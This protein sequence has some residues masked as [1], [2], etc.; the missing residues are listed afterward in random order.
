MIHMNIPLAGL[1]V[2][3]QGVL[4]VGQDIFLAIQRSH[5]QRRAGTILQFQTRFQVK[6]VDTFDIRPYL[7][8]EASSI[9]KHCASDRTWKTEKPMPERDT[10]FCLK[11]FCEFPD[12]MTGGD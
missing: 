12:G 5:T 10:M 11:R 2:S 9:A 7:E 6:N 3:K 8:T 1:D 4:L